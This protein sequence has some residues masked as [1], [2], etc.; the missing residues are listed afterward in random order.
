M[1]R[2]SIW[3]LRRIIPISCRNSLGIRL[4][5]SSTETDMRTGVNGVRSSW[6]SA[7]RKASLARLADSTASFAARNSSCDLSARNLARFI[8]STKTLRSRPIRP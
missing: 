6:L 2:A 7:A 3:T 5:D 8:A 1:R 4:S